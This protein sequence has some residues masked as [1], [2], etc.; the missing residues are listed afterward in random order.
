MASNFR[1]FN[2]GTQLVPKTT[3]T[4]SLA[5]EMDFDTTSNKLN[6]NNGTITDH[7]VTEAVIATLSNK[8][9]A[10]SANFITATPNTAAQ[11][12][13]STG[14][15][16]SSAT[17]VTELGYV[18][19]VTSNI[20]TQI[21][22]LAP[23]GPY[24]TSLTGGVTASGPGAA[25]ATVITNANLTGAVTSVGNATSLVATTNSTLITLSA[26]SLPY[27]QITGAPTALTFS[28]SLVD[29]GGTVTL[30]NDSAS[31]TASQY[32]GTNG[33][34][35]LGYY[36][37]PSGATNPI[38]LAQIATPSTPATGY[39]D[40][41]FKPTSS[42]GTVAINASYN[43]N[44]SITSNSDWI[45]QSFI[46]TGPGDITS[47]ILDLNYV[48]ASPTGIMVIGLYSNNSGNPGTFLG[49][50]STVN[51]S[52]LTGTSAPITFNFVS[53]P[54]L[55]TGTTYWIVLNTSGLTF[56][57]GATLNVNFNNPNTYGSGHLTQTLNGGS[58]WA[59]VTASSL[60]FTVNSN[61][62]SGGALYELNSLGVETPV[63][64]FASPMTTTGDMI[65]EN[66]TPGPA[67]LPIGS[68]GQVL[69]VVSGLPAWS[70][71]VGTQTLFTSSQVTTN[72]S[73]ITST[74]SFQTFSNSPALT[75]T[76]T[77]SGTYKVYCPL[78]IQQTTSNSI[79]LVRIFNT[80][81]GAT[82][83]AES[84]GQ[85]QS[86][87]GQILDTAFCQS[88]YS[89]IAGV[90]YQFDIQGTTS[91]A[92]GQIIAFGSSPFYMF[93]ESLGLTVTLA[94]IQTAVF[95]ET[96]SSGIPPQTI[97]SGSWVQRILNTTQQAQS[98]ASLTSNQIT[99]QAG[100]YLIDAS[101]PAAV[102]NNTQSRLYNVTASSVG[103]TGSSEISPTSI[104]SSVRSLIKGVITVTGPTVFEIDMQV[105]NSNAG[106]NAASFGPEVYTQISITKQ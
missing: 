38:V 42:P 5:G 6:L 58:S 44:A 59:P 96:Q 1:R 101:V 85:G 13:T 79:G 49:T 100:T 8:T 30:K 57:G 70:G 54:Y 39:N 17:T 15:L 92:A 51:A 12:N 93:A 53:G 35:V 65:Y 4:A 71:V 61:I 94:Q 72:S 60:Q 88:V 48:T 7:V 89:L 56:S 14:N 27:S 73:A 103:I 45:G 63:S 82:L 75:F 19:G 36:N 66:S 55:N 20:Q 28:D 43:N 83:L 98:W 33:S 9:I 11:F 95:N 97:N 86:N 105:S 68:T 74:N 2:D 64:G 104:Y 23:S 10:T 21:N 76:P 3:S 91:N 87:S 67:R 81:G 78:N 46:P 29:S 22:S 26:L 37:L 50:S 80:S 40:L 24:I 106:G 52:I 32:Y 90:S 16:E 77:I 25:V 47:V 69:T 62:D 99:L 34:S 84:Q 41:Y 102:T 18:H 31:P